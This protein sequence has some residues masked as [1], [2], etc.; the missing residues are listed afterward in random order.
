MPD[1]D[2]HFDHA[3]K[4]SKHADPLQSAKTTIRP[5]NKVPS[6]LSVSP[7]KKNIRPPLTALTKTDKKHSSLIESKAA[8]GTKR[9][10][11]DEL[12]ELTGTLFNLTDHYYHIAPPAAPPSNDPYSSFSISCLKASF[13][14]IM[15][16]F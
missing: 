4:L 10:A 7:S 8:I 3:V 1:A 12:P 13:W 15:G 5:V 6:R 14:G 9:R 16:V 11:S 2:T